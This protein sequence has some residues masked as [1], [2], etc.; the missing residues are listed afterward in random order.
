MID[1]ILESSAFC[2]LPLTDTSNIISAIIDPLL[3]PSVTIFAN[4]PAQF[5]DG[6]EITYNGVTGNAGLTPAYQWLLNGSPVGTNNDTLISSLFLNGDSL[7]L[8]L[9]SSER[10]LATN[11]ALSNVIIIDR[12]PPLEPLITGPD[13]VCEGK[14]VT[15]DVSATGGTGGPYYLSVDNGLGDGTSFTFVPAQTATYTVTVSDSC[16]TIRN[17]ALTITVNPIPDPSFSIEPPNATILNPYFDFVDASVNTSLWQWYFGDGQSSSIQ[18]P[19][20]TYLEPG[21]YT[22]Q[23]IATSDKGCVDST[24]SEL[25]VENVVIFYIPNSFTPNGDGYNDEFG[26]IGYSVEGYELAVY[27][28][29][30]QSVFNSSGTFD[31]WNGQDKNGSALPEGVYVYSLRVFNDPEKKIRT[32]TVTLVR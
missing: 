2:A 17:T 24:S 9:T 7:Q 6:T 28:R 16:S 5:C 4:P 32:G 30:G 12:L 15:I 11:P 31:K 25:I 8:V 23:L 1:V 18:N 26:P 10:C 29:W 27:G 14:E 22:V 21:I 3:I 13:E 19:S 20:H